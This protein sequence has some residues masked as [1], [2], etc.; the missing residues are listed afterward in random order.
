MQLH[1]GAI[2]DARC[3][4]SSSRRSPRLHSYTYCEFREFIMK[5]RFTLSIPA[6]IVAATVLTACGGAEER[7]AEH[8]ARGLRYFEAQNFDKAKVEFKNVLQIDPKTASPYFYLGQIEEEQKNWRQA[9]AYYQKAVE[10]DPNQRDAQ[11]KLA[12]FYLMV[13]DAAKVAE[14][15]GPVA[16]ERPQD[17]E[18]RLLKAALS[19]LQGDEASMLAQL[20]AIVAEAPA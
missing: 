5:I 8:L 15:L 10:L 3:L 13:K 20:E 14:L 12:K 1:D 9:F 2:G 7:K 19:N 4:H 18:V 16:E 11:L 6:L 17:L